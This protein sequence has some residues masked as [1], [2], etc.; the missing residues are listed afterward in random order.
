VVATGGF[1]YRKG[2]GILRPLRHILVNLLNWGYE[3]SMWEFQLLRLRFFVRRFRVTQGLTDQPSLF[4]SSGVSRLGPAEM[5]RLPEIGL[6]K[7]E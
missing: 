7:I 2:C 4:P 5:F 3:E 1:K 6:Q